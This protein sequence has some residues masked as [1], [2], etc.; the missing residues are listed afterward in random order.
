VKRYFSVGDE[1]RAAVGRYCREVKER[2]FPA[3]E[4]CFK[5]PDREFAALEKSL[6]I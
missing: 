5:I 2:T 1:I 4:H 3:E 6:E